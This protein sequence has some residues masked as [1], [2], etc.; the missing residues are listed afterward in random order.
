[1]PTDT[2]NIPRLA[3][4][5]ERPLQKITKDPASLSISERTDLIKNTE[6]LAVA[7]REPEENLYFQAT[8]VRNMQSTCVAY[9]LFASST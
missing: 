7:L 6:K 9:L 8:Q 5:I 3:A 1:M 2:V 4:S